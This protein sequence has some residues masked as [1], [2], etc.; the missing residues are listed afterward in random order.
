MK[1]N[2]LFLI[3]L[4]CP[5]SSVWSQNQIT[6]EFVLEQCNSQIYLTSSG[7]FEP[8]EFEWFGPSIDNDNFYLQ[9]QENTVPGIYTVTVSDMLC[10][11]TELEIE[12]SCPDFNDPS[13]GVVIEEFQ[14]QSSCGAQQCD[15]FINISVSP[16]NFQYDFTWFK[17]GQIVSTSEDLINAC[18]GDYILEIRNEFGCQYSQSFSICCCSINFDFDIEDFPFIDIGIDII[19]NNPSTQID[20]ETFCGYGIMD[21]DGISGDITHATNANS[22]DGAIDVNIESTNYDLIDF[23]WTYNGSYFSNEI[24]LE[25]LNP[26]TYC[27]TLDYGCTNNFTECFEVRNLDCEEMTLIE[28]GAI[29]HECETNLDGTINLTIVSGVSVSSI[30]WDNGSTNEDLENLSSGE[31]CVTVT[32]TDQCIDTECFSVENISEPEILNVNVT[33]STDNSLGSI[34][35][36]T[37]SNTE[38]SLWDHGA[39]GLSISDLVAGVYCVTLIGESSVCT[40]YTCITVTNGCSNSENFDV[41]ITGNCITGGTISLNINSNNTVNWYSGD[42]FIGSGLSITDLEEGTYCAQ[43]TAG[44]GYCEYCYDI[45]FDDNFSDVEIEVDCEESTLTF[46][47]NGNEGPFYVY[48]NLLYEYFNTEY[49]N[50]I[51]SNSFTVEYGSAIG[52][53]YNITDGCSSYSGFENLL[54]QDLE[55][56]FNPED[57]DQCYSNY[58]LTAQAI[59]ATITDGEPPYTIEWNTG[60]VN[61][62]TITYEESGEYCISVTDNCGTTESECVTVQCEDFEITGGSCDNFYG[63]RV[64]ADCP[65]LNPPGLFNGCD[66]LGVFGDGADIDISVGHWNNILGNIYITIYNPDGDIIGQTT[67]HGNGDYITGP[68][69]IGVDDGLQN[70][71]DAEGVYEIEMFADWNNHKQVCTV[72]FACPDESCYVSTFYEN[73]SEAGSIGCY[74]CEECSPEFPFIPGADLHPCTE[75]YYGEISLFG[76]VPDNLDN[77]CTGGGTLYFDCPCSNEPIPVYIDNNSIF[78]TFIS[79]DDFPST[80]SGQEWIEDQVLPCDNHLG[81]CIF[82]GEFFASIDIPAISNEDVIFGGVDIG[83]ENHII[84][85]ICQEIIEE[86]E[87]EDDDDPIIDPDDYEGEVDKFCPGSKRIFV[88]DGDPCTVS[89]YCADDPDQTIMSIETTAQVCRILNDS[90]GCTFYNYCITEEDCFLLEEIIIEDDQDPAYQA[91]CINLETMCPVE[92]N[93]GREG[94]S[95]IGLSFKSI[96]LVLYPN[97]STDILNCMVDPKIGKKAIIEIIDM[98]GSIIFKSEMEIN[99][100]GLSFDVSSYISGKYIFKIFNNNHNQTYVFEKI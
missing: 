4:L 80:Q 56:S 58:P 51:S 74:S 99:D 2:F 27:I 23:S 17:D 32:N 16:S 14:A 52:F 29:T 83:E 88:D 64:G 54:I 9:N 76:F 100:G 68:T 45:D 55:V 36:Q 21:S 19:N 60:D 6:V 13:C 63:V 33:P 95:T 86:E 30:E 38:I 18:E 96:E 84:A 48:G 77:P 75:N 41:D 93:F 81:Y 62:T 31:Y 53:N 12:V 90:G 20:V 57:I 7:G 40:T 24:D 28:H 42:D 98:K 50:T 44:S 35:I 15:G 91:L 66:F 22:M 94:E 89:W 71:C 69:E 25:N 65:C 97:P 82:D 70:S 73:G 5:L 3:A 43:I 92:C 67:L 26:G 46:T 85:L 37:L 72:G 8:Y 47:I 79:L 49:T 34:S 39:Q 11:S 78:T 59:T 61:T 10:Q 1:N 87:E